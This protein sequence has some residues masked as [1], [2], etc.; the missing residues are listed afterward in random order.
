VAIEK[1]GGKENRRKENCGK[2]N[3]SE[4]N[5]GKENCRKENRRTENRGKK[6]L[7]AEGTQG[8][9]QA[10]GAKNHCARRWKCTGKV[11]S[12]A[13]RTWCGQNDG[14]ATAPEESSPRQGAWR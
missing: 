2:E 4:E 1:D 5:R 9:G 14:C 13:H 7:R 6:I 8:C 3:R 12:K 10:H 11:K